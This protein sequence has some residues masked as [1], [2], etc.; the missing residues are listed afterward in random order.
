LEILEK[1][2]EFTERRIFIGAP[3]VK[4][5]FIDISTGLFEY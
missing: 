3:T 2:D 4:D 5:L 1:R